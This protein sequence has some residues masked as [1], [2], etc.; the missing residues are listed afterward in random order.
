VPGQAV[1]DEGCIG[2]GR[3]ARGLLVDGVEAAD[4]GVVA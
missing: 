1:G 3:E 2:G 4:E